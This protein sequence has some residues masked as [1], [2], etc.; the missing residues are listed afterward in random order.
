MTLVGSLLSACLTVRDMESCLVS[1]LR[2]Q[3]WEEETTGKK[4]QIDGCTISSL[5]FMGMREHYFGQTAKSIWIEG[6]PH[7]LHTNIQ[8]SH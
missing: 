5:L 2:T 3:F 8:E 1:C 4:K 6:D 7:H